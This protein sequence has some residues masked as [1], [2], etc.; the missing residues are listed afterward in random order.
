MSVDKETILIELEV[1]HQGAERNLV[2]VTGRL[3]TLTQERKKA[4]QQLKAGAITQKQ[5]NELLVQNTLATK[6]EREEQKKY[7]KEINTT[8]NSLNAMRQKLV[9]NKKALG[10]INQGTTQGRKAFKK[11]S[12]ETNKLNKAITDQEKG[13]GVATRQVGFYEKAQGALSAGF[14]R[15]SGGLAGATQAFKAFSVALLANPI[16][17]IIGLVV[18]LGAALA[19]F[20]TRSQSGQDE[21]GEWWAGISAAIDVIIDRVTKF[22]GAIAAFFSGDFEEAANIAEEAFSGIGDELEREIALAKELERAS[23]AL[24][25]Q[26]IQFI[27]TNSRRKKQIEELRLLAKDE[28]NDDKERL[29]ALKEAGDLD[30]LNLKDKIS[31]LEEEIALQLVNG[32][33]IKNTEQA[34]K[35]I[36]QLLEE[37]RDI[38][39]EELGLSE[40]TRE[41][42]KDVFNQVSELNNLRMESLRLQRRLITE[43]NTLENKL[44]SDRKAA[45]KKRIDAINKRKAA[46]EKAEKDRLEA[47]RRES[48]KQHNIEIKKAQERRDIHEKA[49]EQEFQ[50]G[51]ELQLKKKEL[52]LKATDDLDEQIKLRTQL[53]IGRYN[54]LLATKDL[55]D[56]QIE[57]AELEHQEKLNEIQQNGIDTRNEA[58]KKRRDQQLAV[59]SSLFGALAGLYDKQSAEYKTFATAQALIDTYASAQ[60]AYGSQL[61]IGDPT[62][63]VRATI[64][65]A[66]AVATGLGNVASI[67]NIKFADGGI[68]EGASHD[69]GG[70]PFTVR[71][72]GGYEMEGG[73]FI[74]N[75][76]DTAKNLPLLTAING[77]NNVGGSYFADG[78]QI[79]TSTASTLSIDS[80]NL[81]S[82]QMMDYIR[83]L[84]NPVVGVKEIANQAQKVQVKESVSI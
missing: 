1:D 10:D 64:A 84:P 38:T 79:A 49:M 44:E 14:P 5:Y 30:K 22:G 27:I 42:Q 47:L 4:Q 50:D 75:K 54:T 61:V 63:P 2:A 41:D 39:I 13:Y 65:A 15:L 74:V 21:F 51:F 6:R 59:A 11:L 37:G 62:S 83:L 9:A 8:S 25:K 55:T 24:E 23:Q 67:N 17:I 31:L 34:K 57:I 69:D 81:Q 29:K 12:A 43:V 77:G 58:D 28:A 56:T 52:E 66:A 3:Q 7:Q 78:G 19:S 73:E 45:E 71:G 68:V 32:E 16:G 46:E 76:E 82:R 70:V 26:S 60:K 36:N 80:N 53:E 40:S 20:F 72:R 48:E 35:R 18:A 33:T